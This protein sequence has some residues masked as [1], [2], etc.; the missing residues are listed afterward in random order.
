[1]SP[2]EEDRSSA[3]IPQRLLTEFSGMTDNAKRKGLGGQKRYYYVFSI[4]TEYEHRG[5]GEDCEVSKRVAQ[6]ADHQAGLATAIMR[7][8]QEK[9]QSE[10]LPIWLEATTENSRYLYLSIGFQEVEKITLGK[11]K[12][13]ADA[14][15]QPDGPGVTL[16]AMVW[17]P[18][19]T[20]HNSEPASITE[21]P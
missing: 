17:W 7:Y 21:T 15:L 20:K 16:Y 1:M 6:L 19:S 14:T 2:C 12:V 5:K 9:A 18:K 3:H 4:G 10:N 8:H 13:A 11:G